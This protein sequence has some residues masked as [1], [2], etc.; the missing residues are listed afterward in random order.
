MNATR[1]YALL[2]DG[3]LKVHAAADVHDLLNGWLPL[4]ASE[5]FLPPGEGVELHIAAAGAFGLHLPAALPAAIARM[6]RVTCHLLDEEVWLVGD[7]LRARIHSQNRQAH[8]ELAAHATDIIGALSLAAALLLARTRRYLLHC[9]AVRAPDGGVWMLAGDSRAGK[10]STALGLARQGWDLI[11]DDHVVVRPVTAGW[12]VDG[13]PRLM[14]PDEGWREG[15]ITSRRTLL[16]PR[17]ESVITVQGTGL[18]KAVLL[19]TVVQGAQTTEFAPAP[20]SDA[21]AMLMRQTAWSLTERAVAAVALRDLT[22]IAAMP[23]FHLRLAPDTYRE[24]ARLAEL[25]SRMSAS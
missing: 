25:L 7:A 13:W 12:Q 17:G 19:P 20:S 14:H 15:V 9:A 1:T 3:W 11:S 10:T 22:F 16:D 2:Q 8:V 6:D 5:S 24:P 23:A 21:L 18:L 4:D